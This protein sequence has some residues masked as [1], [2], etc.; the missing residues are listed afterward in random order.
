MSLM[1]VVIFLS[2]GL[3]LLAPRFGAR[4]QVVLALA[5]CAMTALYLLFGTRY[6]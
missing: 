4:E 3:G 1:L 2:V 5:A 6:M